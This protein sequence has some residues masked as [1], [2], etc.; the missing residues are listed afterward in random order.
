MP[1]M[2]LKVIKPSYH[3]KHLAL[4]VLAPCFIRR[5][6]WSHRAVLSSTLDKTIYSISYIIA[7]IMKSVKV[8]E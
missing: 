2:A 5:L 1:K 4:P 7:D 6:L 3:P 8:L